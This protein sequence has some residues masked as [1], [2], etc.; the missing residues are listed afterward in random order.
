MKN[1]MQDFIFGDGNTMNRMFRQFS[2]GA[3]AMAVMQA[4]SAGVAVTNVVPMQIPGQGTEIR[5]MFNGLPPQPQAYQLEQP[6][7][8]V[9]DFDKAQ[10]NLKQSSIPVA[11]SE[12]SSVDISSDAQRARLTVN[13]ADAGAF[14]TRVEGNT[15]ILKINAA[16]ASAP[17]PVAAQKQAQG[18]SDIGFKRGSAG[19]GLVVIDLL[20]SNTP[21]DV[22]QQGSKIVVR[23]LGNKVPTHLARRLN[24]NDFATPVATVDAQNDHGSGLITISSSGSYEYMAYQTDN[25]LT[26]SLKRPEDKNPTRAK[27]AN[28]YTGKKISLD[29][30]DIEVRRVLQ[31]L[32][33]FTDINMV[34]AD[35]VQG[36][37]TLR[38]KD[39][40]W[41]QALDI[42]LKT[43][44]LD[45][46]RNGNVIWIAPVAELI[47]AE[48]EEAKAIAQSVKLA[49]LQTEYIQL[50]YAKVVDI[51]KLITQGKN[52][53]NSGNS[54]A[55]AGAGVDSLGDSVGSLLSPRGTVSVDPRTNT[56][57]INDTTQK[58]DQIR[59]MIDLLDVAVKQVMVEARIVR[60]TTDFTKEMGV[61]WGILS[62]G[63]AKNNDLLVGGSDTTLWDLK[64]P[65]VG[66][67][68]QATYSIQRPDNLNVDLGVTTQGASR[69]AFGLISLSDFMLDLELSA[70]QADGYGEVIST[71][72]V[73]TGDKQQA[74]VASGQEIPYQ[75]T[76]TAGGTATAT[77]S[78]KDALLSLDVTPSI[79]PDGKV[80][81]KLIIKSDSQAGY[82]QNG[83]IILNKNEINTDVLV[84]NGETV[85]LGGIFEQ[86]TA[87]KQTKVPFL[88]DL[89]YLGRLFRK[90]VKSDNKSELLIFVTP[91]IVNDSVSRN[92]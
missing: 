14:T 54:T 28:H 65:S 6:S 88:G 15:F 67:N 26:I 59:K 2:M 79:T 12:A 80:Q 60:A 84:N 58:I 7:R 53:G 18:I 82:A 3:V 35:S 56:L 50:S 40:P 44:N 77:T 21:V 45:K 85:V 74:R 90:D 52:S 27:A 66:T 49:P 10:Q 61:K 64:T 9:L 37:I 39:V 83:E 4:A 69:I 38:L 51:E 81:M 73:L 33:D 48:E 86:T 24:V 25:R 20:G 1:S 62:Q 41:D 68:G 19:E 70:L 23:T 47:K 72:K 30:Q 89:P 42:V 36:N 55:N 46:R 31:L 78:F 32:A 16:N 87:N 76:S 8:L 34:A 43:K 17:T 13:L 75:A 11:T 22:Q 92:H 63:I 91:R 57:I 5:V 29:F 71:P